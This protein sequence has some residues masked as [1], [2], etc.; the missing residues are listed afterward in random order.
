[1]KLITLNAWG[2]KV[3]EPL[4]KF[5][6]KHDDVDIFCFQEIFDDPEN[7]NP[8]HS[9][10]SHVNL[11]TELKSLLPNHVS[12]F[13]PT[14]EDFYGIA[15]FIKKDFPI[16]AS[17]DVIIYKN[18]K[19]SWT[20]GCA[21]HTRKML[22][23]EI[24]G[25]RGISIM[26]VHGL[27]N[28]KGKTDTPERIE[29]SKRVKEFMDSIKMPKILCGD[30]NL[31][32]DTESLKMLGRDMQDMVKEHGVESTRTSLYTHAETSGKFAD[33]IFLSPD[34]KVIDFK[35][36]SEETSDHAALYVEFE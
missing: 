2:G 11:F 6:K 31:L 30:F 18:E 7:K 12:F 27:W 4:I 5:V 20:A 22:W 19:Y 8:W 34:I 35:V 32:P 9:E 28:G 17:G 1:M 23:L 21:D 36:L 24:G 16:R 25:E 29:Q 15:S 26:N 14:V 10:G 3:R 33:Y 13:C